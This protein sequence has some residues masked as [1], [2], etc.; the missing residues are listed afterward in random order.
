MKDKDGDKTKKQLLQEVAEMRQRISELEASNGHYKRTEQDLRDANM[1]LSDALTQ[2][3]RM[4]QQIIQHQRL[5]ALGQ[6]ASGIAHD[7]N[8]ALMPILGF[9]EALLTAPEILDD[10]EEAISMLKDIHAAAKDATQAVRRLRDFY[11]PPDGDKYVSVNLNK[12]VE[13]AI[14]LTRPKW[15][16]EMAA[17]GFAIE[18]TKELSKVPSVN[19]N[20]SQLREAF[21]NVILNS[22]DA[23]PEGGTITVRSRADRKWV[24]VEVADTGMGMNEEVRYRCFEPFF[25]T[26]GVHGMGMGL[27]LV[28]G[29]IRQHGGTVEVQS[30]PD[31]GTSVMF[32]LPQQAAAPE[33]KAV[34]MAPLEALPPLHVLVIDDDPWSCEFVRRFL[35][36][37]KHSVEIAG[38]GKDG[39]EKFQKGTFDL[40]FTDRAMQDMSGD[41]VAAAIKETGRETP[42]ILLTGF[43]DIMKE[44]GEL[45]PGVD[46]ILSKPVTEQELREAVVKVVAHGQAGSKS[47]GKKTRKR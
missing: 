10:R 35:T 7:F 19:G 41:Q 43:G 24:T 25:S 1:R 28:Y 11:R 44:I 36:A 21:T 39:L 13:T 20:E 15:R 2:L 32:R 8:N 17:Q 27:A 23:M 38:T 45:P 5:S 46:I 30:E 40:V 29:I 26:K 4:Q 34:E 42:I 12:L 37:E 31:K 16:E 47:K 22:V 3:K 14:E 18:V 6:M 33:E 9:S